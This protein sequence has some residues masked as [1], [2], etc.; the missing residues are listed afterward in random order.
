VLHVAAHFP[1]LTVAE[2]AA[3]GD[4]NIALADRVFGHQ[5]PL[6]TVYV[7]S[8]SSV[9]L[10]RFPGENSPDMPYRTIVDFVRAHA[11]DMADSDANSALGKFRLFCGEQHIDAYFEGFLPV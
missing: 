5:L 3:R 1:A 6:P 10:R 2:L 8:D 11:L 9:L 7:Y 4:I